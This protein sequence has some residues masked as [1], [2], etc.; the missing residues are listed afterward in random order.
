MTYVL[1]GALMLTNAVGLFLVVLGLP[2]N[3]L[4]VLCTLL[5]AWWRRDAQPGAPMFSVAVLVA[6]AVLALLG[7]ILEFAA[8]MVGSQAAGGTRRGAAGALVGALVGG[9]V[10]TLAIPILVL[11]SLLGTCIGAAIGAWGLELSGSRSGRAALRAGAGA[12]VGR[13]F[14]TLAKFVVGVAI[15]LTVAIAAFWP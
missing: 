15:W 4:M 14:G 1:A 5:V 9:I 13:L 12:G 2:G 6:I 10:G 7:E 8:G 3:W 11:G